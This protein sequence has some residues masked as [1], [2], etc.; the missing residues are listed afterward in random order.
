MNYLNLRLW[1]LEAIER[2]WLPS[3]SDSWQ[4]PVLWYC[5]PGLLNS[6]SELGLDCFKHN[7]LIAMSFPSFHQTFKVDD[8][9][10]SSSAR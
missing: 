7:I 6:K 8:F 3:V 2:H 5:Q 10:F 4:E 1:I 9:I